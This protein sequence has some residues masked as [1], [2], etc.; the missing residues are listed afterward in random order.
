MVKLWNLDDGTCIHTLL[1]HTNF[2]GIPGVS[3]DGEFLAAGEGKEMFK[4]WS[5]SSG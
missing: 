2:V 4:I 1:G 5:I 3:D